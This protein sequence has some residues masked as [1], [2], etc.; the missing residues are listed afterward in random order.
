MTRIL[1]IVLAA[2]VAAFLLFL[3]FLDDKV[4]VSVDVQHMSST[5]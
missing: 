2:L 3:C 4:E 1:L 5:A